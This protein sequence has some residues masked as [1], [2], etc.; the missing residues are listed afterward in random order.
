MA[1]AA[2][3]TAARRINIGLHH[4]R[5]N[6]HPAQA[7]LAVAA[8]NGKSIGAPGEK[9][10]KINIKQDRDPSIPSGSTIPDVSTPQFWI[11]SLRLRDIGKLTF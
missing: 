5:Y 4:S 11:A 9:R 7:R 3:G 1:T 8:A 10:N 6:H 2:Q